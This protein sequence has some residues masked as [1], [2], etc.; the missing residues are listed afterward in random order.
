MRGLCQQFFHHNYFNRERS[1][2]HCSMSRYVHQRT[3]DSTVGMV[4]VVAANAAATP[5]AAAFYIKNV[6]LHPADLDFL[7]QHSEAFV[8]GSL[9]RGS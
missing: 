4:A 3:V 8:V 5:A 9:D 1:H 2:A 6:P 7:Q